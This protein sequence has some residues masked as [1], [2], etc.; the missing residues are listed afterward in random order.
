MAS[1]RLSQAADKDFEDIFLYGIDSFGLDQA[2]IYQTAMKMRFDELAAHPSLYNAVDHI[3][4]GYRRSVFGSHSIYYKAEKQGVII[5]RI[6]GRQ[7]PG[8]ALED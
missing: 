8:A 5:V 6:L 3:M 2:M 1:Y 4:K 7:D